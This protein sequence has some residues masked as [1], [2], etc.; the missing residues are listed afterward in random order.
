[1]EARDFERPVTPIGRPTNKNLAEVL[2]VD[3]G[4][5][6]DQIAKEMATIR[7]AEHEAWVQGFGVIL[8]DV[9]VRNAQK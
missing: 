9:S 1:M 5:L 6:S 7:S 3:E 2:G 8:G 4:E